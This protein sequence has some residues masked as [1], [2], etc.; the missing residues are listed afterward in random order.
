MCIWFMRWVLPG[1]VEKLG[2]FAKNWQKMMKV[3]GIVYDSI[4]LCRRIRMFERINFY[5]KSDGEVQK[6]SAVLI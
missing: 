4:D 2:R 1:S 6:F 3:S 5:K